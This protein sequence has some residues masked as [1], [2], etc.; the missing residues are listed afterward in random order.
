MILY[1]T[2]C[3]MSTAFQCGSGMPAGFFCSGRISGSA[4]NRALRGFR[5]GNNNPPCGSMGGYCCRDWLPLRVSHPSNPI[6]R[7]GATRIGRRR[8]RPLYGRSAYA[9]DPLMR[10]PAVFCEC[11]RR[12][13]RTPA[14]PCLATRLPAEQLKNDRYP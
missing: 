6:A 1:H 7:D 13:G 9:G 5:P 11:T 12:V 8:P 2:L 3:A 14:Q 10:Q 4:G